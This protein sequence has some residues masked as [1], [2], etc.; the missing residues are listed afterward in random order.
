MFFFPRYDVSHKVCSLNTHGNTAGRGDKQVTYTLN[1]ICAFKNSSVCR[2]RG[3]SYAFRSRVD[4]HCDRFLATTP[5]YLSLLLGCLSFMDATVM[6]RGYTEQ[7][8]QESIQEDGK[9][10]QK[11]TIPFPSLNHN[12]QEEE[13][14]KTWGW[15]K[16]S[17]SFLGTYITQLWSIWFHFPVCIL[18]VCCIKSFH[19]LHGVL[20]S[21]PL[22]SIY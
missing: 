10:T 6:A 7:V 16:S 15:K 11:R 3:K 17:P 4:Y 13:G 12:T 2:R 5:Q 8:S 1:S 9:I 20:H 18:H 22:A 21:S 19:I 14:K